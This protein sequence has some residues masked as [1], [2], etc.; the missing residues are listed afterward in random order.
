MVE[1]K[2]DVQR[3]KGIELYRKCREENQSSMIQSIYSFYQKA[4]TII[5]EQELAVITSSQTSYFTIDKEGTFKWVSFD[6]N[7]Y[8]SAEQCYE[9]EQK[10]EV[11]KE[12]EKEAIQSIMGMEM[13]TTFILE[14]P[15]LLKN[16]FTIIA[17][18]KDGNLS[19]IMYQNTVN[20]DKIV[21]TGKI[22]QTPYGYQT[23]Y[24]S[25]DGLIQ[26]ENIMEF[27]ILYENID[28]YK[29]QQSQN[30]IESRKIG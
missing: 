23:I 22:Y 26:T 10:Q 27:A 15:H 14:D 16:T 19:Q 17:Q 5:Y 30:K 9:K 18:V 29:N 7:I 3:E 21:G 20:E 28:L 24:T 11:K 6:G 2:Q 12:K 8:D 13:H 25:K 1:T 4:A